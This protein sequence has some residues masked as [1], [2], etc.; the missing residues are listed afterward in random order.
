MNRRRVSVG[1]SVRSEMMRQH[2]AAANWWADAD[3]FGAEGV[4]IP[5]ALHQFTHP[6]IAVCAGKF[7]YFCTFGG[8]L[9]AAGPLRWQLHDLTLWR[10]V[11]TGISGSAVVREK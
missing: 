10:E 8:W 2:E 7:C 4:L 3:L 6:F 5:T 9:A 1:P 11:V